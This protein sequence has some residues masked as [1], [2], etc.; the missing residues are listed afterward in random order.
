MAS[1]VVFPTVATHRKLPH[2]A[3]KSTSPRIHQDES[4]QSSAPVPGIDEAHSRAHALLDASPST[5]ATQ[6]KA[7]A[8]SEAPSSEHGQR[9]LKQGHDIADDNRPALTIATNNSE[10]MTPKVL[11]SSAS[12]TATPCIDRILQEQEEPSQSPGQ[13]YQHPLNSPHGPGLKIS[14]P[15]SAI[16][17]SGASPLSS[18]PSAAQQH[19]SKIIKSALFDAFGC[20]YHPVQHTHQSSSSSSTPSMTPRDSPILRP[21][22]G[23]SAPITPLELSADDGYSTSGGYFGIQMSLGASSSSSSSTARPL[24]M[25]SHH[26]I[27][28]HYR[29]HHHHRSQHS[30]RQGS[31]HHQPSGLTQDDGHFVLDN[32]DNSNSSNKPC[33]PKNLSRRPSTDFNLNPSEHPVLCSLHA[34]HL[35]NPHP[36]HRRLDHDL[37][38]D[39]VS[40]ESDESSLQQDGVVHAQ[41]LP[42]TTTAPSQLQPPPQPSRIRSNSSNNTNG[43]STL[44]LTPSGVLSIGS[45]KTSTGTSSPFPMDRDS[46]ECPLAFSQ[47]GGI[48]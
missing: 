24:H 41:T 43:G 17:L 9:L 23:A 36:S 10:S 8:L 20:L 3:P 11:S 29:H 40:I 31:G 47:Q 38:H 30:S 25:S 14:A 15:Q 13:K 37:G 33:T 2:L 6:Q 4:L 26:H 32:N 21:H 39:R 44:P 27:S 48:V 35:S 34:L 1:I 19:E 18:E 12:T 46:P 5:A 28:P 7:I 22:L 16:P 42:T 45:E